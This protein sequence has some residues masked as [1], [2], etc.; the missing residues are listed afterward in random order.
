MNLSASRKLL[1]VGGLALVIFAMSY[2]LWYALFAE[3]QAL[4]GMG[5]SLANGFAQAASRDLAGSHRSIQQ[6]AAIKYDYVR[7]VDVHSHWA[8]LAMI[9]IVLGA[10]FDRV[11]FSERRRFYLAIALL[12]GSVLFPLGVV[13]QTITTSAIPSALAVAGSGMVIAGLVVVAIGFFR[14][15][16]VS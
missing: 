5:A 11:G 6:Y 10:M 12:T 15:R 16:G 2:G 7:H 3:H 8:G 4:E 1:I 14:E 9:L 13:L